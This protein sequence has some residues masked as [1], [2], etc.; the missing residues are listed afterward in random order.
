[1]NSSIQNNDPLIIVSADGHV[2]CRVE[3]YREYL[4]PRFHD[5]LPELAAEEK[6]LDAFGDLF[7]TL[8]PKRLEV[9]DDR[10]RIRSGGFEASWDAKRR[11]EELDAEGIAAEV[12]YPGTV[13]GMTPFF[14]QFN[15]AYPSDA[16]MAGARAFHRWLADHMIAP[17]KGRLIGTADPGPAEDMKEVVEELGWCADRKFGAAFVPGFV[18]N[19]VLPPLYHRHFEPF[20]AACQDMGL[21]P[22]IHAGWN[23]KQG[24]FTKILDLAVQIKGSASQPAKFQAS[25]MEM[26]ALTDDH[27]PDSMFALD[28]K[29]RQAIWQM[30]FGGVFDRYPKLKLMISE[31]R[32][33]WVPDQKRQLDQRFL[34]APRRPNLQRKPSEY[35]GVNVFIAPSSPRILEVEQRH[36]IGLETFVFAA[37]MP[38]PEGTWPN[39]LTWLRKVFHNTPENQLRSILGEN[40]IGIY[41]LD[42]KH[43]ADIASKIGPRPSD[44]IG[45]HLIDGAVIADFE[46]RSGFSKSTPPLAQELIDSRVDADLMATAS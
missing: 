29:P 20:W 32:A 38:H 44:I 37:D 6:K 19:P 36:E 45:D 5:L 21:V 2:G 34:S 28:V 30:I 18:N 11:L 12:V 9:I 14:Y 1:M 31:C 26:I 25:L 22:T 42:Q 17:S 41:G 33:D 15:K 13:Q 23:N 46:F 8:N 27:N 10:N 43:L 40:A 3:Q 24:D 4:D 35:F 39:T 7:T 16:R